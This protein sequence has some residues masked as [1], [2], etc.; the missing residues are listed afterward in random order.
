MRNKQREIEEKRFHGIEIKTIEI[1][2]ESI[3]VIN[4]HL[5]IANIG[6]VNFKCHNSQMS[7]LYK[8]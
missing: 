7:I 1:L 8:K 3:G 4:C 6:K 2:N 5:N